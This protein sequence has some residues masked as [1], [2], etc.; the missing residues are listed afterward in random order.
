MTLKPLSLAS[1]ALLLAAGLSLFAYAGNRDQFPYDGS[2]NCSV[3]TVDVEFGE[4]T[5]WFCSSGSDC[6]DCRGIS[7]GRYSGDF[8]GCDDSNVNGAV[9]FNSCIGCNG[10][11]QAR[12]MGYGQG[13]CESSCGSSPECDETKIGSEGLCGRGRLCSESC[14]CVSNPSYKVE[15]EDF[16]GVPDKSDRCP[17]TPPFAAV[18]SDGCVVEAVAIPKQ[19]S[20]EP[21]FQTVMLTG[22][23]GDFMA[24]HKGV[25]I[26]S[27][28][29]GQRPRVE[30]KATINW[31]MN[32][33]SDASA[34]RVVGVNGEH[35]RMVD[36]N[37][38]AWH[39][40]FMNPYYMGIELEQGSINDPYSDRQYQ[41]AARIVKQW[42]DKYGFPVTKETVMGH[43]AS[44]QG[45]SVGKTDPGYRFDWDRFYREYS[46][47]E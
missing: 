23:R 40:N 15:D 29:G 32:P 18:G 1:L 47:I 22:N 28:R 37:F 41:I 10:F 44:P 6:L 19:S 11:L 2:E 38:E 13:S 8:T 34:H 33:N 20:S 5:P 31:F 36:D 24:G 35:Y 16:D 43:E 21:L 14:T 39:A 46:G 3:V 17:G 45:K 4:Y 7:H 12:G 30:L 25:I 9:H 26:H 27:T 42:S